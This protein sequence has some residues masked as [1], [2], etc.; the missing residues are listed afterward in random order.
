MT[1]PQAQPFPSPAE[2]DRVLAAFT[3]A[4]GS[5]HTIPSRRAKRVVV[6][7]RI[8]QEFEPGHRYPEA[9]VVAALSRFHPDHAALRRYLV[10][11]GFLARHD[12]VYWRTG[13]TVDLRFEA[14]RDG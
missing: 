8:A 1:D 13:G 4:D 2:A 6:L 11:E 14:E 5:L 9:A 7:D 3:R 12:G 10:D